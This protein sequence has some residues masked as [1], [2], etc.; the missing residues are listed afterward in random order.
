LEYIEDS[1]KDI[2]YNVVWMDES[3]KTIAVEKLQLTGDK[4]GS[5]VFWSNYSSL[6][7]NISSN[8]FF[9]NVMEASAFIFN[10]QLA[11]F[12]KGLAI[13][14]EIWDINPQS[15]SIVYKLSYNDITVPA[16]ILQ[17]VFFDENQPAALNFGAIGSLIGRELIHGFDS[18]GS[19]YEKQGKKQEWWSL[20]VRNAY[21]TRSQCFVNQ[22]SSYSIG[23]DKGPFIN[24]NLTLNENIADNAGLRQ[25]YY[26][27]KKYLTEVATEESDL[28]ITANFKHNND[29]LFFIG[30]S[31]LW[32]SLYR[33]DYL[34]SLIQT[35]SFSP[36][37][38]RAMGPLENFEEFYRSFNCP[39]PE[40]RCVIW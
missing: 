36:A 31:Q 25:S 11:T 21:R 13:N 32:C 1:L 35:D 5:P 33:P 8:T 18:S 12:T 2:I 40:K 6:A 39:L 30:W 20:E 9:Y 22:Y 23:G 34:Q 38:W 19:K 26:A 10:N 15:T 4:V 27:F 14:K 37:K 24:G 3:T 16:G 29:Q 28:H 17:K 7:G